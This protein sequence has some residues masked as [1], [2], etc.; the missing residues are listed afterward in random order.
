MRSSAF[1]LLLFSLLPA[2]GKLADADA[3][4]TAG[5]VA[6][7]SD[8]ALPLGCPP[9]DG[10]P[11]ADFRSSCD[12]SSGPSECDYGTGLCATVLVCEPDSTFPYAG[13]WVVYVG[14]NDCAPNPPACP[15]TFASLADRAHCPDAAS[16]G[17]T[18]NYDEGICAC[19]DD[20]VG[21]TVWGCRARTDV[22]VMVPANDDG[23]AP[24]P[25]P[26]VRPRADSACGRDGEECDY[27]TGS[28]YEGA[29][30]IPTELSFGPPMVC[31][32]GEWKDTSPEGLCSGA[33]PP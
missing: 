17:T 6:D 29:D 10:V 8:D 2:C 26:T 33:S 25:C 24:V 16:D 5:Q 7:A 20:G 15:A 3:L 28:E 22:P 1:L 14:P 30:C 19:I 23:G 21:G 12:Y 18:C 27:F 13:S 32:G 9:P 11:D 4:N 31:A